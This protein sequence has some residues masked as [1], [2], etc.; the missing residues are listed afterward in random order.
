MRRTRVNS[1]YHLFYAIR[2]TFQD[3]LD[4]TPGFY[5]VFKLFI[6]VISTPLEYDSSNILKQFLKSKSHTIS[7]PTEFESGSKNRSNSDAEST[8]Y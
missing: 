3:N 8:Q 5:S 1:R 2:Y 7:N 4:Q 6:N